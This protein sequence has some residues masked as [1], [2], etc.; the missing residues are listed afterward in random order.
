[1]ET[2][3]LRARI[4]IN[5]LLE[6]LRNLKGSKGILKMPKA[7]LKILENLRTIR[8]LYRTLRKPWEPL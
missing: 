2:F 4:R 5:Y 6:T 1:M 3:R 8:K 7:H